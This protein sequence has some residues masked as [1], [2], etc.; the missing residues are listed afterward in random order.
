MTLPPNPT[1]PHDAE[2]RRHSE[3]LLQLCKRLER[4][5]TLSD[6]LDAV[7]PMGESVFDYRHVWLALID[8]SSGMLDFLTHT[9]S[10]EEGALSRQLQTMKI[11]VKGDAL[12]E[13]IMQAT[14]VVVVEDARTDPRTNKAVV[15]V[16][17][18]RTIV[19]VPLIMADQRMGAL[20]MGTYGDEEGVRPPKPW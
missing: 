13:E 3:A 15:A 17:H 16:L 5:W 2:E 14:H 20:G 8:E 6:V 7:K 9:T 4:A 18:N 10:G 1:A 19:N 11:P 12:L